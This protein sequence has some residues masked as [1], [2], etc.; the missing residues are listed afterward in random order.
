[1]E[2]VEN[3]AVVVGLARDVLLML[4]LAAALILV[5]MVMALLRSVRDTAKTVQEAVETISEK[6][7]EPAAEEVETSRNVG[8]IVGFALG[9]F[10]KK[11]KRSD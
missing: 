3:I 9:I 1:M 8:R 2:T 4:V 6:I 11:K 5:L 10:R 7:I